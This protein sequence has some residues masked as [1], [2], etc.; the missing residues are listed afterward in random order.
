MKSLENQSIQVTMF[1][2]RGHRG[3]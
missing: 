2:V 1:D 3:S